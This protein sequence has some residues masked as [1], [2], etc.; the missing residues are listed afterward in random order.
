MFWHCR[1]LSHMIAKNRVQLFSSSLSKTKRLDRLHKHF[2]LVFHRLSK[3]H[4]WSW[5]FRLITT[6][7]WQ[8]KRCS[9]FQHGSPNIACDGSLRFNLPIK[10]KNS[11]VGNSFWATLPKIHNR[12]MLTTTS[13]IKPPRIVSRGGR[14]P[15]KLRRKLSRDPQLP[16]LAFPTSLSRL[17]VT[18]QIYCTLLCCCF[19]YCSSCPKYF[20]LFFFF[21][22]NYI[23]KN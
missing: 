5:E 20:I 14:T 12:G 15:E 19:A 17:I 6:V 18:P 9:G 16:L 10:K 1:N 8:S 21:Y 2:H 7:G 11:P 23:H 3:K 13:N 4:C 22:F